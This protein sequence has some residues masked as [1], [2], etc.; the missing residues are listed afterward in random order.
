MLQYVS[1]SAALICA[2]VFAVCSSVL[3]CVAVCCSV[4]QCVAVRCSA[5]QCVAVCCRVLQCVAACAHIETSNQNLL[6]GVDVVQKHFNFCFFLSLS[7]SNTHTHLLRT[8]HQVR[9]KSL[10]KFFRHNL[11]TVRM[12]CVD[13]LAQ[14]LAAFPNVLAFPLQLISD[15]RGGGGVFFDETL[16]VVYLN[17]LI[18]ARPDVLAR[19][20]RLCVCLCD[21]V[22]VYTCVCVC[23][24]EWVSG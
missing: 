1:V 16:E 8:L 7:L 17:A 14:V 18:E 15:A 9:L 23:A 2:A 21:C 6:Q 24:C 19:T 11:A 10:L 13:I 22:S 12:A 5:L 20:V 3:Q 4:L